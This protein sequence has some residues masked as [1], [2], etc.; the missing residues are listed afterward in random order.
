MPG[1]G[2]GEPDGL[3]I[4]KRPFGKAN[5]RAG[6][7][8]FIFVDILGK[9]RPVSTIV[10]SYTGQVPVLADE[11]RW[12]MKRLVIVLIS[13]VCSTW[14]LNV[15]ADV[16]DDIDCAAEA[17][18][19]WLADTNSCAIR[20]VNAFQQE[21]YNDWLRGEISATDAVRETVKFHESQ[22]KISV[23]DKE[24]YLYNYQVAQAF[25]AGK[26]TKQR[27]YYLMTAKENEL[28]DRAR[29]SQPRK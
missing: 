21:R 17:L 22:T 8:H 11:M 24:L 14:A 19:G 25:D 13:V 3:L 29:A 12:C 4:P 9:P 18:I 6:R 20:K 23:Y 5:G 15:R 7:G 2:R 28:N 26:I 27:A 16:V 1:C 10:I